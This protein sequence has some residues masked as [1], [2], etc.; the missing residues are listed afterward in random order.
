[1]AADQLTPA[2]IGVAG[3][4]V[5]AIMVWIKEWASAWR[6]RKRDAQYLAIRIVCILDEYADGCIEVAQDHGELLTEETGEEGS[7]PSAGTPSPPLF[8]NDVNWKSIDH[9]LAYRVLTLPGKVAITERAIDFFI[10]EVQP[11]DDEILEQRRFQ[12]AQLGLEAVAIAEQL[13]KGFNL[14]EKE[15]VSWN[16]DGTLQNIIKKIE[17][18]RS[19]R[20]NRGRR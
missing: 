7:L 20:H 12:Y 14:P 6:N 10:S 15:D 8:P 3:V 18:A 11:S 2:F 1:M 16:P 13:R 9:Q 4:V 19:A 5:G 17:D